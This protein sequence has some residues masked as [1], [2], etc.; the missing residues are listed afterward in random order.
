MEE[1]GRN[2]HLVHTHQV[3][4]TETVV[5]GIPTRSIGTRNRGFLVPTLR[6]GTPPQRS[7]L[8]NTS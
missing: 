5:D 3:K 1:W 4:A 7:A 2:V 6:V 8:S